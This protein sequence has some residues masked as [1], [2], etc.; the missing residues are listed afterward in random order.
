LPMMG[1][2]SLFWLVF[3]PGRGPAWVAFWLVRI[4]PR[5]LGQ[6]LAQ[7]GRLGALAFVVL[8]WLS[9]T[10][11]TTLVHSLVALGLPYAWGLTLAMALRFLPSM[12]GNFRLIA[13][14]Q[15]ARALD[16]EHGNL[17]QRTRA[18]TPIIVAMFITGLRTA[19]NLARAL[20]ARALGAHGGRRTAL[21]ALHLRQ[22]DLV[23]ILVCVT[24]TIAL[25]WAR[26]ALELGADPLFFLPKT[27]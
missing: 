6:A 19:E 14:A 3:Y 18:Y 1:V 11:Q 21:R 12:A 8:T 16:L 25:C 10:D 22:R 4:T 7:A 13:D 26:Y 23:C 2:V 20:E 15:R 17:L 24:L 27:G 9:T 5:S